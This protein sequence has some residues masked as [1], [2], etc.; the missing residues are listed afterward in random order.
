LKKKKCQN[1]I[2]IAEMFPIFENSNVN[3]VTA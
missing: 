1:L 2:K 3:T